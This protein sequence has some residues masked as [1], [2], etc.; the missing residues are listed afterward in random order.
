MSVYMGERDVVSVVGPEAAAY[1]Q[2]QIS[3]DVLGLAVNGSAWS[4]ILQPQGKVDAWFRITKVG[5]DSYLLDVDPGFG[6]AL[7][8]RLKRFKLRTKAE[9]ALSTWTLHA[10]DN[11]PDESLVGSAPIVASSA[12]GQGTD[13]IGPDLGAPPGDSTSVDDY[14]RRRI[15]AGVPAMGR[16][17]SESTIPAEARIV[18]RSVSFTKG[19]YTGQELVARVDSRGDNT[20]RRLRLVTGVGAVPT[21]TTLQAADATAGELTSVVSDGDGWVGLAYVKRSFFGETELALAGSPVVVR[22][23]PSDIP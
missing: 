1:L 4:L 5:D 18:D 21:E 10:Y 7:L 2:G 9:F 22:P 16:E 11:E 15:I 12:T 20:P 3:Q 19:C 14:L 13:V 6:E 23:V 17:L 8:S